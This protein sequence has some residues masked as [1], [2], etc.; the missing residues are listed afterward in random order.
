MKYY[1]IMWGLSQK[2]LEGSLFVVGCFLPS[3]KRSQ[4]VAPEN[5]WFSRRSGFLF[6]A[7]GIFSGA[8]TVGFRECKWLT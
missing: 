4:Q 1:P 5:G 7:T 2:P 8:F 3:L 6:E